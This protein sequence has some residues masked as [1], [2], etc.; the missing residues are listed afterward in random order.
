MEDDVATRKRKKASKKTSGLMSDKQY[1]TW[2]FLYC[3]MNHIAVTPRILERL[4]EVRRPPSGKF[5]FDMCK[6]VTVE[7]VVEDV[8]FL[9]LVQ[10]W[11]SIEKPCLKCHMVYLFDPDDYE[12]QCD[13]ED[14]GFCSMCV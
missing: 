4:V 3:K 10:N 2:L 5:T 12:L 6:A 14:N 11:E 9:C 7:S 13:K 1:G 8:V